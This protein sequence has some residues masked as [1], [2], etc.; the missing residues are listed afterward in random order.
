MSEL[1]TRCPKCAT[2]FRISDT[3]LHSA[4]GVVRC[5]SCL[6]VFNAREHIET[7]LESTTTDTNT[8]PEDIS[9]QFELND[10]NQSTDSNRRPLTRS[11]RGFPPFTNPSSGNNLFEREV[12]PPASQAPQDE[13]DET[14]DDEAWALEL[15][16]DD[17]EPEIQ[18]K[19]VT[20]PATAGNSS[21]PQS[22]ADEKIE[23]LDQLVSAKLPSAPVSEQAKEACLEEGL[24]PVEV[25]D[26]D[27]LEHD[28]KGS[29]G[30]STEHEVPQQESEA[31]ELTPPTNEPQSVPEDLNQ[32]EAP[33]SASLSENRQKALEKYT[34]GQEEKELEPPSLKD[35]IAQLEPE[36]LEVAWQSDRATW[37]RKTL[38]PVLAVVA[39]AVLLVQV[40]WLEYPRLNRT[41]PYRSVYAVAC[42]VLGCKL[43]ALIDHS[44]IKTSNL[45]VRSHPEVE[46][47]L[48][49]DVIL[50]NNAE[51]EQA[52]PSLLLTFSNLKNEA[53]AARKLA[54]SDYLG[55]ELSGIDNMPVKQPIH[56]SLEIVDP[57]KDAVSYSIAIID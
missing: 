25:D 10:K 14:D 45:L 7:P 18:L 54:P 27:S 38:W 6:S 42:S 36:P 53:V 16:K 20:T 21:Q 17:D 3:L 24:P 31:E 50:Q 11:P 9:Y 26:E 49:V 43:P 32:K 29:Y 19:K 35:V 28:L 46:N 8:T 34:A 55:G 52:F 39:L 22:L 37:L 5:G 15:L 40:A 13:E 48:M 4:K 56:I 30:D 57:G 2:A 33:L 51:F 12:A 1:I 41:E 44:Q 23:D 47:A